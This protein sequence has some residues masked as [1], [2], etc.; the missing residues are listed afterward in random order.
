[1]A[2]VR[3]ILCVGDQRDLALVVCP[4]ADSD[5]DIHTMILYERCRR[6]GQDFPCL[7]T[8]VADSKY[9]DIDPRI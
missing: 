5:I 8:D 2:A 9:D 3:A 6:E 4:I 1:M 7:R